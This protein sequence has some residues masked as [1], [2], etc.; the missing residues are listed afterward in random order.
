MLLYYILV[1][2]L[3]SV[4]RCQDSNELFKLE[5]TMLNPQTYLS[6]LCYKKSLQQMEYFEDIIGDYR[7]HLLNTIGL[8]DKLCDIFNSLPSDPDPAEYPQKGESKLQN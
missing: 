8:S 5:D 1:T 4:C 7:K 3:L 2:A 6:P